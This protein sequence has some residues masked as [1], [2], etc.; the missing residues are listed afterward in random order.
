MAATLRRCMTLPLTPPLPMASAACRPV[1]DS[2]A[3]GFLIVFEITRPSTTFESSI[4]LSSSRWHARPSS[5]SGVAMSF[6]SI[7]GARSHCISRLCLA[8]ASKRSDRAL[9]SSKVFPSAVLGHDTLITTKS[10]KGANVLKLCTKSST[11]AG[12]T[13]AGLCVLAMLIPIGAPPS[14]EVK[15]LRR[16]A[17][18]AAP[19]LFRPMQLMTAWSLGIRQHRGLSFPAAGSAEMDP[20]S[21]KPICMKPNRYKGTSAAFLSNPAAIP[22]GVSKTSR[23]SNSSCR[24]FGPDE[25]DCAAGGRNSQS[26]GSLAWDGSSS[27]R[28]ACRSSPAWSVKVCAVSASVC[29]TIGATK[30]V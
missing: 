13:I 6:T 22:T 2:C 10:A 3:S 27:S 5:E 12:P 15:V 24:R 29:M 1:L 14:T 30:V 4:T 9:G 25:V 21:A 17:T 19:S 11:A 20:T 16:A 28:H 18:H 26:R 23:P 7:G 8:M